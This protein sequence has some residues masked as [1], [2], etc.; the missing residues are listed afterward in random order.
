M[1]KEIDLDELA[2]KYVAKM[3][4]ENPVKI[5]QVMLV[6]LGRDLLNANAETT[7]ITQELDLRKGERFKIKCTIKVTALK[8][9]NNV[10]K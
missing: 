2:D 1:K 3:F 5:A 10:R 8:H 4:R 7:T 9:K 6:I